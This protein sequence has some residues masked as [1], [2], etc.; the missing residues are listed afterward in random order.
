MNQRRMLVGWLA[1][2][3]YRFMARENDHL[4]TCY[5]VYGGVIGHRSVYAF[6]DE[7]DAHRARLERGGE[8]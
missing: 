2:V 4:A 1:V 7:L 8:A 5:P 3:Y 6:T